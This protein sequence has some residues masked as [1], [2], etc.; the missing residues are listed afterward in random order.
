MVLKA[1]ANMTKVD[2]V[3]VAEDLNPQEEAFNNNLPQGEEEEVM[4]VD[5]QEGVRMEEDN[6]VEVVSSQEEEEVADPNPLLHILHTV[7]LLTHANANLSLP[8]RRS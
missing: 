6:L 7:D 4:E 8:H 5:H 3:V 2:L 1:K